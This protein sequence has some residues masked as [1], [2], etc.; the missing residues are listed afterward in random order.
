MQSP[1]IETPHRS[2]TPNWNP[3]NTS[4]Q[5][6]SIQVSMRDCFRKQLY[7]YLVFNSIVTRCFVCP[8]LAFITFALLRSLI[9]FLHLSRHSKGRQNTYSRRFKKN[10]MVCWKK[11][12]GTSH[13][14]TFIRFQTTQYSQRQL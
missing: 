2:D 4:S 13:L 3:N 1:T 5:N 14:R 11:V 6:H 7:R 10:R 12:G 9:I 8:S